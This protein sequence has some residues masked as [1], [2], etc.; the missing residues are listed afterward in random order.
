LEKKKAEY[1]EKIKNKVAMVHK[2]AEEKRAIVEAQKGEQILKAEE[3]AAKHRA[4]GTI[5]KKFF[6]CF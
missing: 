5:P 2:Q 6:G 1:G 3:I 4:T